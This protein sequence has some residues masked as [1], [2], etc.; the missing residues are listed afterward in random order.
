NGHKL[1]SSLWKMMIPGSQNHCEREWLMPKPDV[2]S[3]S[4][5]PLMSRI[6]ATNE[7]SI[8]ATRTFWRSFGKLSLR[9]Q[10]KARQAFAIFRQNPFDR[11]LR[12]PQDPQAFGSL[13]TYH[14]CGRDRNRPARYLLH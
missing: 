5:L 8:Q 9:Q 12:F 6:P 1:Q 14:L 7:V 11:R 13:R 3:T 2:L 10:T 4:I